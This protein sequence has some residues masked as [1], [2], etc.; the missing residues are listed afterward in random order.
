MEG[1]GL[2]LSIG[3]AAVIASTSGNTRKKVERQ[4]RN[5]MFDV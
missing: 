3:L 4:L 1:Y 2:G 5:A